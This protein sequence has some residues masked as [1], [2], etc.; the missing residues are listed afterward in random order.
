M[1]KI[2]HF[3][4]PVDD[5]QRATAFTTT[6]SAGRSGAS[7]TSRTGWSGRAGTMSPAPT[8]RSSAAET[9]IRARS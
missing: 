7:A 3:E 8:G 5:P 2:V 4:I 9:C 1:A 6:H